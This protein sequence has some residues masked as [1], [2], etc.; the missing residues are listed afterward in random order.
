[1][2]SRGI[3]V[4]RTLHIVIVAGIL[5]MPALPSQAAT[6]VAVDVVDIAPARTTPIVFVDVLK[7]S[8]PWSS[9]SALA[10]DADGDVSVLARGQSAQRVIFAP[11][12]A[13]PAGEYV[14]LF[15]GS[16]TFAVDGAS[17]VARSPGRIAIDVPARTPNGLQLRLV[18]TN[19]DNPAR[20]LRLI[21]PG[22]E[23]TYASAPIAPA[24]VASLSGAD[25]LRFAQ[26]SR[27]ATLAT[28]QV[29]PLRPRVARVTQADGI[30]VAPEYAIALSNLTGARPW[31]VIPVGATD[32]Y[33][34]GVADLA[35]RFLDPR[36]HPMFEYGDRLWDPGAPANAYARMAAK[37]VGLTADPARAASEWYAYRS[38]QVFA[39]VDYV[40]GRDAARVLHVRSATEAFGA[41]VAVSRDAGGIEQTWRRKASGLWTSDDAIDAARVAPSRSFAFGIG[42]DVAPPR[43][44]SGRPPSALHIMPLLS[45]RV[46]LPGAASHPGVFGALGDPLASVDVT[47]EGLSDWIAVTAG[48]AVERKSSGAGQ[49]DVSVTGRQAASS[50][51]G[52]A[53]LQWTDGA[54]KTI[55]SSK[56]GLSIGT[57]GDI[58]LTAPADATERVLR[59]YAGARFAR[60]SIS[61]RLEGTSYSDTS[62]SQSSGMREGV[63]TLVYHSSRPARIAVDLTAASAAGANGGITLRGATLAPFLAGYAN[64]QLDE[65]TYHNGP[66]RLGWDADELV[67]NTANVGSSGFG[68]LRTLKVDGNVLAQP[69]YL[70]EYPLRNAARHNVL[71]VATE[72]DSIYEFDADF[73]VLLNKVSLGNAQDANDVGCLDIRP[74]Y[75]ISSTPVVDRAT[76]TMYV[77]APTEPTSFAFH[78]TLHALSVASLQDKVAPVDISATKTLSNGTTISFDPQNQMNRAGLVFANNTLYVGI[79]SHC[80][81]NAGA[82]SGWVL[83]YDSALNKIGQ[84]A[85]IEDSTGYLLSSV[86]M[87]G[88]APP[89]DDAGN[90]FVVTGNGAFDLNH[91]GK[92]YG[93]SVLRI[94]PDLKN[95]ADYFTPANWLGLN[96]GDID[97]GSGGIMLL[98]QQQG[99]YPSLAVTMGKFSTAYLLDRTNLGRLHPGDTGALQSIP[100]TGGGVWGGPAYYSGPTGQLVYYQAGGAPLLAF[101]LGADANG[102]PKLTLTSTGPSYSG[103]GGSLPIVSSNGQQPGTGIVWLVNRSNPLQLEA[104]DA[105]NV[106]SLLFSGAAGIWKNPQANGFVTP[107]VANGKVFVPAS[108]T[109]SVF[110]LGH[111]SGNVRLGANE[112]TAGPIVHQLHGVIVKVVANVLTL[113]LRDG[114][115]VNVDITQ[116][117]SARHAGVL[118]VGGAVVAYGLIDGKGVF[119]ATSIGH[120]SPDAK[121]WTPDN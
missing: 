5:L 13:H 28:S 78:A 98:P 40:Y 94:G 75:G 6:R 121:N 4:V 101:S 22:F 65:S 15:A 99:L 84:F 8:S 112:R 74:K 67:L 64:R 1:M 117:R 76:D 36:L 35:H 55:G 85:T 110:G 80:D 38:A 97:F 16:G 106:S 47:R 70:A 62:L 39:I 59:V 45:A 34:Y 104:Y 108:G 29:W 18:A 9:A 82:I 79:G 111:G 56:G 30:G 120:T 72:N 88:F 31:F 114:R 118:P 87:T 90:L 115:T 69:L 58:R 116:A 71:I 7:Q 42:D 68:L 24:F 33:V 73:G 27:A 2:N 19:P 46:R 14:L 86:W 119:R 107:L 3:V 81:N 41:I 52:F 109:I 37:N 53:S 32:A 91:G 44:R 105:T 25:A 43:D 95:V 113:R 77:V 20:D 50:P 89:V 49:I 96:N 11:A 63:F 51:G 83:R 93:E 23:R 103:Y 21:L 12:Q 26:W 66:L 48:A 54:S 57:G 17:I 10:T 60:A 100:N 92:N 61:A 102:V